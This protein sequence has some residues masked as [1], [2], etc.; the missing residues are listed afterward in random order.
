MMEFNF[1]DD[2]PFSHIKPYSRKLYTKKR[3]ILTDAQRKQLYDF[4]ASN[5]YWNYLAI[6]YMCYYCFIRPKEISLLN[7]ADINL[8]GQTIHIAKEVA[9]NDNESFR[10]IPDVAMSVIS[11]LD[12]DHPGGWYVFSFDHSDSFVPGVH[13]TDEREI[14]RFWANE[15]RIKLNWPKTLQFYSLKDTGITNMLQDGVATN[16]VQGQA[17]HSSL[18]MTSVYSRK[19]TPRAK[20]DIKQKPK[21]FA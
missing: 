1:A 19:V 6:C 21:P 8:K 20:A 10:T 12:L 5:G 17:D 15:V 16:E 11:R 2:N 14:A 7:I 9:K 13:P 4:L 18:E 3:E